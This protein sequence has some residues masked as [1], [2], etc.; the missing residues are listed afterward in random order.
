[1]GKKH[2]FSHGCRSLILAGAAF[3]HMP[4]SF[5]SLFSGPELPAVHGM[6]NQQMNGEDL[7][8]GC[9]VA[10]ACNAM[11]PCI[12][13]CTCRLHNQLDASMQSSC[14]KDLAVLSVVRYKC[15]MQ[16]CMMTCSLQI[17]YTNG[18]ILHPSICQAWAITL[19]LGASSTSQLQIC[20]M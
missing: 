14:E 16:A 20:D 8:L 19:R 12:P 7:L 2:A 6:V 5:L 3:M 13:V 17:A 4:T 1:M 9:M 10:A 11:K 18:S 15:Q